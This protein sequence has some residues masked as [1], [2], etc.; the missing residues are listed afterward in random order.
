[1]SKYINEVVSL[2]KNKNLSDYEM[3][4]FLHQKG[5]KLYDEQLDNSVDNELLAKYA[6]EFGYDWNEEKE[7]WERKNIFKRILNILS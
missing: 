7:F 6:K 5:I 3:Q 1:M 2:K 4:L